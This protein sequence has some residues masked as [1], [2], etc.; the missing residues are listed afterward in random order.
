MRT[1]DCGGKR[2]GHAGYVAAYQHSGIIV[3]TVVMQQRR[4][5]NTRSSNAL[6]IQ[7]NSDTSSSKSRLSLYLRI[8]IYQH[9]GVRW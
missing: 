4:A 3:V 7:N 9:T 8:K 6:C 1:S 5:V 2:D